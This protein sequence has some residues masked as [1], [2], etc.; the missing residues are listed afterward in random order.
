M[1]WIKVTDQLP[2]DGKSYL[3]WN[4]HYMF[5]SEATIFIHDRLGDLAS[6]MGQQWVDD[7]VFKSKGQFE[8]FGSKL[9]FD[10]PKVYY[11]ELPNPPEGY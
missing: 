10:N 6:F 5:V 3:V 7:L 11:T 8:E 4:G 9:Y 2:E 1:R